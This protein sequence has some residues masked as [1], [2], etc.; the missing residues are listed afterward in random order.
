MTRSDWLL[1]VWLPHWL[2]ACRGWRDLAAEL[3][4]GD[5]TALDRARHLASDRAYS[6]PALWGILFATI[7]PMRDEA[8]DA[9][10]LRNQVLDVAHTALEPR[11]RD[12]TLVDRLVETCPRPPGRPPSGRQETRSVSLP[13]EAWERLETRASELGVTTAEAVR[14]AVLAGL[15][16]LAGDGATT[17]VV[18][19]VH[20]R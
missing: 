13:A 11:R 9:S 6:D 7:P 20:G 1:Q 10:S 3:R 15:P 8:G 5:A 4:A 18:T 17:R 2:D 14:R 19:S 12:T 16:T